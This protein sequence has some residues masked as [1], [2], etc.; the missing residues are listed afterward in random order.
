MKNNF[1]FNMNFIK[2]KYFLMRT[3]TTNYNK[4][5]I[6]LFTSSREYYHLA[7]DVYEDKKKI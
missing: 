1:G 7:E 4:L 3:C 2:K 6:A 5:I